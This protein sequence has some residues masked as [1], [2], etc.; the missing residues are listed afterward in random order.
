[1]GNNKVLFIIVLAFCAA[2]VGYVV[3]DNRAEEKK[4]EADKEQVDK[5]LGKPLNK[6][7]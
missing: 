3:Y 1:M 6:S 2:L 5:L 4:Q 7:E